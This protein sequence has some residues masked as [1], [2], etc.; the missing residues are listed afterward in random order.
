[1]SVKIES[2]FSDGCRKSYNTPIVQT[3][4]I[5]YNL[6]APLGVLLDQGYLKKHS[7]LIFMLKLMS[8]GTEYLCVVTLK[9]F[10]TILVGNSFPRRYINWMP[11]T[12]SIF[13]DWPT[14][15]N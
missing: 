13:S 15:M 8:V 7:L 5:F 10:Y 12:L 4:W 14:D 9:T 11:E 2:L 1:M 3:H 6:S